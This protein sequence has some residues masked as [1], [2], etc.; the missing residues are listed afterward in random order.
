MT[1]FPTDNLLHLCQVLEE[2]FGQRSGVRE[3]IHPVNVRLE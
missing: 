3:R 2:V 1:G